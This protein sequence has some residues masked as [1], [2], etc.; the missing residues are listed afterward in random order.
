MRGVV[1]KI[2][3][4]LRVTARHLLTKARKWSKTRDNVQPP[5]WVHR[6]DSSLT[7]RVEV[8]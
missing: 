8:R 2:L 5:G 6:K 7:F 3:F 1:P 4:Q